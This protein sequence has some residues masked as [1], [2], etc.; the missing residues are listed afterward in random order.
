MRCS[1]LVGPSRLE[2][3]EVPI[4][5]PGP[6]E[7]LVRVKAVGVCGS[8]LH[9]FVGRLQAGT[10]YPLIMGHE[11]SGEVAALGPGVAGVEVG[12]R[13]ACAPDRPCGSCEWCLRGEANVCPN[14]RFAA[15]H[16][17]PG[18]LSDYYVVGAD[19]LYPI[20]DSVGFDQAALCE[21]LAIG[22][23]IV[24]NLAR[25]AGGETY[26]IMG[27]GTDGLAV[28]FAA[29]RNCASAAFVSDLIPQRLEAARKLGANDTCNAGREDFVQFVLD[30]TE[31]RGVDVAVE[32]AGAVPAIQQVFRAACIHGTAI[33]MGI[34]PVD[35]VEMDLT[36]ARRRELTFI[37]CRRTV[38]KY[39]RALELIERH[40]L[41][42]DILITHRFPLE[43]AQQAFECA[44]DRADGVIKPVILL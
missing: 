30:R 9:F 29:L 16:G 37:A 5:E 1:V 6:Q 28:L 35:M 3:Q 42:T 24:E 2:L 18:C 20:A 36:A 14:V 10:S 27:A 12:T 26:A 23:H 21:P 7:A 4:P 33:V 19:Q 34:P 25:P 15:S 40:Q 13:V 38:D 8:D 32:A 43:Q 41:D 44:R 22:L 39:G 17:E 31:G 11:F